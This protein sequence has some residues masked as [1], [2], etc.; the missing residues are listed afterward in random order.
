MWDEDEA[1]GLDLRVVILGSAPLL[2]ARGLTESLAGRFE[3]IRLR[4][5]SFAEMTSAFGWDLERFLFFGGYPGAVPLIDDV[6]R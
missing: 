1:T 4:S 5:L 3:L 6:A 2:V